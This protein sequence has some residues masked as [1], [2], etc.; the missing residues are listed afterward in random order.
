MNAVVGL[1][2]CALAVGAGI[3]LAA[4]VFELLFVFLFWLAER[5]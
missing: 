3:L 4:V 1:A 5:Y 2:F